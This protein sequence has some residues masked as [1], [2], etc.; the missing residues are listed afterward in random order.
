MEVL[1]HDDDDQVGYTSSVNQFNHYLSVDNGARYVPI[2]FDQINFI[3]CGK[4]DSSP[5]ILD[6]GSSGFLYP[7][8]HLVQAETILQGEDGEKQEI[9]YHEDPDTVHVYS[10]I[11][12]FANFL[13]AKVG[14]V[15]VPIE[16]DQIDFIDCGKV[17]SH[18]VIIDTGNKVG[19]IFED[20]EFIQTNTEYPMFHQEETVLKELPENFGNGFYE[21]Y[22]NYEGVV[23]FDDGTALGTQNKDKLRVGQHY[24]LADEFLPSDDPEE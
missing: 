18:P 23:N 4:V 16:F 6:I 3:N 13:S 22:E 11:D 19:Y 7:D 5:V 21:A 10:S 12:Q 2:E 1:Y 17:V 24:Y 20:G 8:G 15:S 14:G 9:L